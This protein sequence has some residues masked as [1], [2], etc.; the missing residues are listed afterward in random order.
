MK[1]DDFRFDDK[2]GLATWPAPD[3][4]VLSFA[5]AGEIEARRD[6]ILD[7]FRCWVAATD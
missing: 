4:G 5:D 1:A 6:A 7:L 3:R 2:D